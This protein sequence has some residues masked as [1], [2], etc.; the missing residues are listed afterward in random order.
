MPSQLKMRAVLTISLAAAYLQACN[1]PSAAHPGPTPRGLPTATLPATIE[2]LP[3]A[4]QYLTD[5]TPVSYDPFDNMAN[6]NFRSE[7]GTLANGEFQLVGTARWQSSFWPKQQFT[8]GQGLAIRF[9]VQRANAQS[10]LV[11]VTGDWHTDTFRQFGVYN[12]VL[13]KGDLFMGTMDLGGYDINGNLHMLSNTW[14]ELLLAVGRNGKFL[15]VVWNPDDETQRAI[16]D[17]VAGPNWAGRSW[18]F[19]P[20]ANESEGMTFDDFYRFSFG[21]IK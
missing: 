11:L 19:L 20:K 18:V 15:A 3:I 6:W 12:A 9:I 13:P 7:T 10:E 1:F 8:D 2:P 14:Y 4:N 5:V 21:D 16:F 17:V